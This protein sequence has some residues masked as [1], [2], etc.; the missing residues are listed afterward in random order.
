METKNRPSI[1]LLVI[2]FF[3][4]L[5]GILVL[6][7]ASAPYSLS[8]GRPADFLIT[9]QLLYGIL[10]GLI[11]G[12]IA[13]KINI[14]FI[15]KYSF[16]IFILSYI[17]MW[18]VFIPG[19]SKT[20]FGATRWLNLGSIGGFQP[21]EALKLATIIYASALMSAKKTAKGKFQSILI[22]LGIVI[23]VLLC[24]SN[25]STMVIICTLAM[26]IF[27]ISGA[28]IRYIAGMCSSAAIAF[29]CFMVLSPY[30]LER[31]K[32]FL[33]PEL[34]PKD[35]GYHISQA[36]IAIGSGG[37]FGAGLGLGE[38]KFGFVPESISDSIFTIYAAETGFIGSII[39]IG[40]FG[41][42]TYMAFQ[43]AR[44]HH[45]SFSKFIAVGIG[46]WISL[47]AFINIGAMTGLLPLSG[48]P[49][50]F[51]TYGSSHI[52]FEFIACGLLLNISKGIKS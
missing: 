41:A 22:L 1:I 31:W 8:K 4:F 5:I 48:T 20:E 35:K 47:Q 2:I 23:L 36:L 52:I 27:F 7:T 37:I 49:L 30:R 13:Y 15:K 43:I 12:I 51:L 50:P 42:F 34:D 14:N 28:P 21:S 33:N 16:A 6:S 11:L 32:T 10:P 40:L 45:D 29:F 19:L 39:L 26:I 3:L 38:Q 9:H 18:L 44:K 25:L 24:Q 17:S 46:S